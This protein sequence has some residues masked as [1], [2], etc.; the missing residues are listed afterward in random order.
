MRVSDSSSKR[1]L[2]AVL[3][4]GSA[5]VVALAVSAPAD[6][7]FLNKPADQW[8]EAEALQVL[9]DSPWAHTVTTTV[10]DYQCDYEHAAFPGMYSDES[11]WRLDSGEITPPAAP[12]KPD[13]AEYVIRIDSVKPMQAAVARL[14][15]LDPKWEQYERGFVV[16]STQ[17]TDMKERRYN[18]ADEI[19]ISVILKRP[20]PGGASFLDY[21]FPERG[22]PSSGLAHLW[23]CMAIKT[24]NGQV[25]AVL[26]GPPVKEGGPPFFYPAIHVSFP[27]QFKGK[28]LISQPEEKVEFRFIA[29]QRVFETTFVVNAADLILNQPKGFVVRIPETVDEP[30]PPK[31]P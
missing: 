2:L 24:P 6:E 16:D 1:L 11:A 23:P 3:C 19:H 5:A 20:G 21:A 8:T 14:I 27:S 31:V 7:S 10:Q 25:S 28:A 26:G 13:G 17:P 9:N 29:N 18:P 15:S 30:T 4:A 22:V 12:V